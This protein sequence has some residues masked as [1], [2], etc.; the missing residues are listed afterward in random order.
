MKTVNRRG[1]DLQ[2]N[3]GSASP[4]A[5]GNLGGSWLSRS[6]FPASATI[7]LLSG[8]GAGSA[9]GFATSNVANPWVA[10]GI[11]LISGLGTGAGTGLGAAAA[12]TSLTKSR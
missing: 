7:G 2:G 1:G 3:L 8:A 11:G 6:I 10:V 5:G 12:L 4:Q 9:I